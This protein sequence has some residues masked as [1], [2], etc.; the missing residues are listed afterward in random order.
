MSSSIS[1]PSC[2]ETR[3]QSGN[4]RNFGSSLNRLRRQQERSK[5]L[6]F[7]EYQA[8]TWANTQDV[9]AKVEVTKNAQTFI[10]WS[11][12]EMIQVVPNVSERVFWQMLNRESKNI[13]TVSNP[14]GHAIAASGPELVIFF[15]Y[16]SAVIKS[17]AIQGKN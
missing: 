7:F 5:I 17:A 2:H 9:T 15:K 8:Q 13:D 3:T 16:K 14:I 12:S 11:E 10:K 4:K 6:A 1:V